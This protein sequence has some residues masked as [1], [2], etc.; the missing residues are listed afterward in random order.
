MSVLVVCCFL[1]GVFC[2]S[3]VIAPFNLSFLLKLPADADVVF[4]AVFALL[5]VCVATVVSRTKWCLEEDMLQT[6]EGKVGTLFLCVLTSQ[7]FLAD[8]VVFAAWDFVT[9][10]SIGVTSTAAWWW[11]LLGTVMLVVCSSLLF[12]A[13]DCMLYVIARKRAD[14]KLRKNQKR[15]ER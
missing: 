2:Y 4:A 1:I 8:V 5:F 11:L 3:L 6:E 10:V 12:A 14:R 15:R 13:L 9:S 7:E